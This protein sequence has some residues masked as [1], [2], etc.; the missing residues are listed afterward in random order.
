MKK[1]EL[2]RREQSLFK[3][4]FPKGIKYTEERDRIMLPNKKHTSDNGT[5]LVVDGMNIAY[6][7][8]YAYAKLSYRGMSTSILYGFMNILRPMLK[9]FEPKKV[10]ICWDGDKHPE[11][12]KSVPGYKLHR[13]GN[14]DPKARKKF[15][16]QIIK[17]QR[18][19]Y[20]LGISQ[21]RNEKVEGDDMIYMVTKRMQKIYRVIIVS[22]DKDFKQLV[23]YDV[24]VYNPRSKYLETLWAF[25][26]ANYG[27]EVSQYKDYLCLVGDKSD[28]IPGYPG[29]GEKRA[30]NLLRKYYTIKDYLNSK[31]DIAGLT[32][33]DKLR[34]IYLRNNKMINLAFFNKRFNKEAKISYING[35]TDPVFDMEKYKTYCLDYG[36][37]TSIFPQ[38]LQPFQKL[39]Q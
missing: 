28:D 15:L 24:S 4:N 11:R 9:E 17:T 38:F 29:I 10:I 30:A 6:Q 22:G 16:K 33:K 25:P 8:F 19:L 32:D 18:L 7:A 13:E 27:L 1:K 39:S 23:N 36:L 37:R 34:K 14:R 2:N 21:I 35:V 26:V 31:E 3:V 12:I 5:C 20:Y